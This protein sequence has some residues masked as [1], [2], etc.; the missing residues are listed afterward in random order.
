[1]HKFPCDRTVSCLGKNRNPRDCR[2]LTEIQPFTVNIALGVWFCSA[3]FE[4]DKTEN[5]RKYFIYS[6]VGPADT[7]ERRNRPW[8]G[9]IVLVFYRGGRLLLGGPDEFHSL[10]LNSVPT[11]PPTEEKKKK[12]RPTT[13][14]TRRYYTVIILL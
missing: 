3:F 13:W 2:H 10:G 5:F 14:R 6:S 7:S 8:R 4:F 11:T 1:M 12:K 9:E